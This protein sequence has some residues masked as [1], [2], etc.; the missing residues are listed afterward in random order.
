MPACCFS[1]RLT[2]IGLLR[3]RVLTRH[4]A[5]GYVAIGL[6]SVTADVLSLYVLHSLGHVPL[7][8][9]ATAA[10]LI[11]F[12]INFAANRTL[13]FAASGRVYR[14]LVRY[15]LLVGINYAATLALV[16][17]FSAA[18]QSYLAGKVTAIACTLVWN[19]PAYRYWV[20]ASE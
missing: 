17:A 18:G 5:V 13:V 16:L 9:A 3:A 6:A 1:T 20:F 4:R 11:G 15:V 19:F 10:Y 7:A 12:A 14:S 8:P 2:R